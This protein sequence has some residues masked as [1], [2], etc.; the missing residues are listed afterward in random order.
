MSCETAITEKNKKRFA[1]KILWK[2]FIV[3]APAL[4]QIKI[5]K[6]ILVKVQND[7]SFH[8]GVLETPT[9]QNH[10]T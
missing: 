8:P 10:Q 7:L 5:F 6:K 4:N 2:C 9:H 1:K 3:F